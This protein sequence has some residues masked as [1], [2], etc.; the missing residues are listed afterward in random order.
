[1]A[2][3]IHIA[4][5]RV[6]ISRGLYVG[7]AELIPQSLQLQAQIMTVSLSCCHK[8]GQCAV[9][10]TYISVFLQLEQWWCQHSSV[11]VV[12]TITWLR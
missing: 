12:K 3:R 10:G 4:I 11:Y 7:I 5:F 6:L 1:M 9:T 2:A 8:L